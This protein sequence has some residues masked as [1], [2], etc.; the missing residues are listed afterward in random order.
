MLLFVLFFTLHVYTQYANTSDYMYE[1]GIY[2]YYFYLINMRQDYMFGYFQ[3][4][5]E[6]GGGY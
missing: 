1:N 5:Q 6:E 2:E 3:G 4:G